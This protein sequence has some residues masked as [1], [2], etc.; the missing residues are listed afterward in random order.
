MVAGGCVRPGRASLF[1]KRVVRYGAGSSLSMLTQRLGWG[2]KE[3]EKKKKITLSSD[4]A[5]PHKKR[6]FKIGTMAKKG[7][8]QRKG[9]KSGTKRFP[10][11]GER[12]A[13][14]RPAQ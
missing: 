11:R 6:A 13:A 3:R 7:R 12:G 9:R 14:K 5:R 2:K 1:C 8:L 4:Q 10:R